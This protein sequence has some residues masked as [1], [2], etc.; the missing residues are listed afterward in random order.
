MSTVK[1]NQLKLAQGELLEGDEHSAPEGGVLVPSGLSGT[2][3]DEVMMEE[4]VSQSDLEAPVSKGGLTGKAVE[5]G[6][7]V[8]DNGAK[9]DWDNVDFSDDE[10]L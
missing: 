8:R 3:S 7:T 1:G 4:D 5:C 9:V 6:Q 10:L 2:E